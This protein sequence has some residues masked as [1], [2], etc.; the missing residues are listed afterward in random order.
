MTHP[1]LFII[2]APKCGT[3]SLA[4][5][6]GKH[7][8]VFVC[9]PKEPHHFSTDIDWNFTPDRSAYLDL[10]K[11]ASDAHHVVCDASVWYLYSEVAVPAILEFNPA[12]KFIVMVRNPVDMVMSLHGEARLAGDEDIADV[13]AAW[14]AQPQRRVQHQDMHPPYCP[15]TQQYEAMASNGVLLKR[16]Y[17]RVD[18]SR[19]L[20]IVFDDFIQDTAGEYLRVLDFLGLPDD[21]C[22]DFPVHNAMKSLKWYRLNKLLVRTR[23]ALLKIGINVHETGVIEFFIWLS[24]AERSRRKP[25]AEFRE[26]LAQAFTADVRLLEQLLQRDLSPW[27]RGEKLKLNKAGC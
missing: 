3:T 11:S 25:T 22:R 6:L 1:N 2:G 19:V 15:S 4:A 8:N 14:H 7:H 12:A 10:F 27:L 17:E 20:V 23:S 24:R 21:G 9:D 16:L 18:R 13:E 26:M 5:Y